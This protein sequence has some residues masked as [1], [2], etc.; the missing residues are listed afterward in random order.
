MVDG[1]RFRGVVD[2]GRCRGTVVADGGSIDVLGLRGT[3]VGMSGGS[4]G[5]LRSAVGRLWGA[6]GWLRGAVLVAWKEKMCEP[7]RFFLFIAIVV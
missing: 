3:E 4:V 7:C 6:V 5:L 1:C 2:G